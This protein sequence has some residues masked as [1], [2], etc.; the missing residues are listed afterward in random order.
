MIENRILRNVTQNIK[1]IYKQLIDEGES[2]NEE[3][4]REMINTMIEFMQNMI[5][6]IPEEKNGRE[7]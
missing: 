7:R 2:A 1:Y 4:M 3:L 6:I 5:R